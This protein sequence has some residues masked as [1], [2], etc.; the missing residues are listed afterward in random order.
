MLPNG[1]GPSRRSPESPTRKAKSGIQLRP[2]R[3]L[4]RGSF[5]NSEQGAYR[6]LCGSEAVAIKVPRRAI[7]LEICAE[8]QPSARPRHSFAEAQPLADSPI[9]RLLLGPS[10]CAR[11]GQ[12]F[13]LASSRCPEPWHLFQNRQPR[14]HL[15]VSALGDAA[16]DGDELTATLYVLM[17]VIRQST[18]SDHFVWA[19]RSEARSARGR[20]SSLALA[21]SGSTHPRSGAELEGVPR[22]A[23]TAAKLPATRRLFLR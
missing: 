7:R 9:R 21:A 19:E 4:G 2:R 11:R 6:S 17:R 23:S 18:Q 3:S 8:E 15:V 20:V 13:F 1:R 16:T 5:R 10:R 22:L 12:A 14:V